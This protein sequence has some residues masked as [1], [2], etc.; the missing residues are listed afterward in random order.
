[1]RKPW[2]VLVALAAISSLG[3]TSFYLLQT[4][5][6]GWDS[7]KYESQVISWSSCGENFE[8]GDITVPVDYENLDGERIQLSLVKHPANNKSRRLGTL[9]VNPG[10]PGASGVEYGFAAEYIVSPEILAQYDIVGFDPRGVGGSS[11]ERCLSNK[12]TDRLIASN[13]P[14]AVGLPE[15]EIIAASKMLAEK[16]KAKLGDRLKHLGSVDVVRDMELMRKV[17]GEKKFN[18]LGKSYGTY[19]GLVYAAMYPTSVGRFV[20]DGVI[21]P[22]VTTNEV[23]KTQAIGFELA[24]DSFLTDC[25][26]KVN[27][28]YQGDLQGARDEV[29]KIMILLRSNPLKLNDARLVTESILVL[30]MVSSLYNTDTGWPELNRAF[31]DAVK[32]RGIRLQRMADDY[33]LRDKNGAY[34]SNEN[35]I[36][37]IVNCIDREVDASIERTKADSI[38]ISKIAPHFGPYIAWS[39]LPCDYWPFP[40][41]RPPVELS[42]PNLPPFLMVGTTRDPATPYEWAQ[43]V[44]QRFPSAILITAD[45]DGHTGHGRGS[46]CVDNAV[47]AYL[48]KG[49][50]PGG[51]LTCTL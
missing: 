7:S 1:M 33:V 47:D 6:N 16:C 51:A 41:I 40:L 21:D 32:G 12:E 30:A 43:S 31:K 25:I 48:L 35:E 3:V 42:G 23:N 11:A 36:A 4:E 45:G 5:S 27:C 9:F 50:L 28:F 39:A 37:Y 13:G 26:T 10:G 2:I 38:A 20:L 34:N 8:C 17:F 18:Y 15:S 44:A 19:L 14:P 49:T 29:S 22:Q 46:A 24:L